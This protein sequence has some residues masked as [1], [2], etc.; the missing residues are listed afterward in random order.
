V[1]KSLKVGVAQRSGAVLSNQ[2]TPESKAN[3]P[4]WWVTHTE[5]D[6]KLFNDVS[7]VL[8][9]TLQGKVARRSQ[10]GV[11]MP[12][13]VHIGVASPGTGSDLPTK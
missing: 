3:E 5:R 8:P 6:R 9:V 1:K 7:L 12:S 10:P 4:D 2:Q 11:W 13:D